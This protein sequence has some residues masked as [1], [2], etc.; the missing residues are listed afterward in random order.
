M[1]TTHESP[2]TSISPNDVSE[3]RRIDS[4]NSDI[5][6]GMAMV[7]DISGIFILFTADNAFIFGVNEVKVLEL[8]IAGSM[9]IKFDQAVTGLPATLMEL[10]LL[11]LGSPVEAWN[12]HQALLKSVLTQARIE[13]TNPFKKQRIR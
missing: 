6:D 13:Y 7:V 5:P 4:A 11:D 1:V 2:S 8:N 3:A 9:V 10:Q 12:R